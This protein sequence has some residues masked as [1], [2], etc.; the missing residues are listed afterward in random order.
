MPEY[1]LVDPLRG[2]AAFYAL[3]ETGIYRALPLA[4]GVFASREIPGFRLDPQLLFGETLPSVLPLL[5]ALLTGAAS[6]AAAG[7]EGAA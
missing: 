6:D 3:D 2:D 7:S 5:T 1:W 4:G